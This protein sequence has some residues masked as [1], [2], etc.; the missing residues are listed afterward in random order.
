M[1]ASSKFVG[2]YLFCI[3]LALFFVQ[4]TTAQKNEHTFICS[5]Y[6]E[7]ID[8]EIYVA[9]ND[10]GAVEVISQILSVIGLKPNFEIRAANVPNAAAV[11]LNG[12][13]YILYNPK[14]MSAINNASGNNWAGIS[15]IAHE[16]GH[17]LNGHTLQKGGSRPDLELEADEFSGFVLKKLGA[18]ISDA[19]AAMSIAASQHSSHTHPAKRD[20]LAAIARGWNNAGTMGGSVAS[21]G[22]KPNST[23]KKPAVVKSQPAE[24]SVIDEKYIAFDVRFTADPKGL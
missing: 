20:R 17:H 12:T 9:A 15:I 6:G 22:S 7:D 23:I 10:N 1:T 2:R 11:M 19:Q 21:T 8:P 5:Y 3:L 14:F 18:S 24:R 13:R 4:S 16:I